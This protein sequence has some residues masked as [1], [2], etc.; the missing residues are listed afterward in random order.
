VG[1]AYRYARFG[2]SVSEVSLSDSE[3]GGVEISPM[4]EEEV[5]VAKSEAPVF[6]GVGCKR[7]TLRRRGGAIRE[8]SSAWTSS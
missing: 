3:V 6:T 1:P 8:R 2:I 5:K 7:E 4:G